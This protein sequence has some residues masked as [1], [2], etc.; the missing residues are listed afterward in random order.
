[1]SNLQNFNNTVCG[2]AEQLSIVCPNSVISNNINN[3]KMIIK[4]YPD[5]I[6]GLFIMYVL[7]DKEKI[8][9]GDNDYFLKKS[10]DNV[11]KE[12]EVSIQ[13]FFEFKNVWY[14]LSH[15]N[16]ELVKQYM[17]CL[18]YYSQEYFMEKYG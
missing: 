8:D 3:L 2:L 13:K 4:S 10:Y 7:P 5:K 17:Q 11:A 12:N 14:E 9:S 18:C 16:Q 15:E 6:I 1:M